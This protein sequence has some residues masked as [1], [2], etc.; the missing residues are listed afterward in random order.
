MYGQWHTWVTFVMVL[1]ASVGVTMTGFL[2]WHLYLVATNQTT[3]EFQFNKLRMLTERG[4]GK[5]A[6]NEYDVGVRNNFDQLFAL[7]TGSFLWGMLPSFKALP[8][9]GADY[10]TLSSLSYSSR[11][12]D[13]IV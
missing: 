11:A 2:G 5:L 10:P 1:C 8:L 7:G 9:N 6:I 13:H 4:T 3:I 12:D